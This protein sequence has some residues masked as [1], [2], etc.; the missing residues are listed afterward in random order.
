MYNIDVRCTITL[1]T[2][3]YGC[4]LVYNISLLPLGKSYSVEWPITKIIRAMHFYIFIC[5]CLYILQ[6]VNAANILIVTVQVP[7]H[8]M[9]NNI[10]GETLVERGHSVYSVVDEFMINKFG[11]LHS[12][13]IKPLVFDL[14]NNYMP[15]HDAR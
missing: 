3:F 4:T 7:S 2:Q 13:G 8:M 1:S 14:P 12:K 11:R 6:V 15:I 5:F 9:S 10:I